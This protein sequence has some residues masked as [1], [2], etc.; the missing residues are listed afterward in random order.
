[1]ATQVV[2]P[3]LPRQ[4][5]LLVAGWNVI[6]LA[7]LVAIAGPWVLLLLPIALAMTGIF[8]AFGRRRLAQPFASRAT[9]TGVVIAPSPPSGAA[10]EPKRSWSGAALVPTAL[11][12]IN[13]T[14]PLAELSIS[15]G[16]VL[17]RVRPAVLAL[18]FGYRPTPLAPGDTEVVVPVTRTLAKGIAIRPIGRPATY[19]FTRE[20]PQILS[21]LERAGFPVDWSEQRVRLGGRAR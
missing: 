7:V 13:A 1:M 6:G 8:V 20:V 21:E 11:G 12:G 17:V 4:T 10:A 16:D 2:L 14:T 19:F 15:D 5:I 3:A 9:P 18:M